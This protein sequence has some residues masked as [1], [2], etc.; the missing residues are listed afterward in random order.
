MGYM[1]AYDGEIACL[2]DG[3][4]SGVHDPHF[5]GS[6]QCEYTLWHSQHAADLTRPAD[7]LNLDVRAL[8]STL[9]GM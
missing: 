3:L 5:I 6:H 4:P 1:D 7:T 8:K 2:P 9:P